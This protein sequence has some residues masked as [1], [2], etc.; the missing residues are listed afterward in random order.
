MVNKKL[1]ILFIMEKIFL[2]KKD[3]QNLDTHILI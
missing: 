1:I 2:G 3:N